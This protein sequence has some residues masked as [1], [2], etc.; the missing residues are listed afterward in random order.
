MTPNGS[1]MSSMERAKVFFRKIFFDN[2]LS[3]AIL[4]DR[5]TRNK[6]FEPGNCIFCLRLYAVSYFDTYLVLPLLLS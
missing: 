1:M 3:F 2:A 5:L 6:Q 4:F